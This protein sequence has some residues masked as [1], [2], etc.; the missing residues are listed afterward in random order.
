[1]IYIQT[2]WKQLLIIKEYKILPGIDNEWRMLGG[3]LETALQKNKFVYRQLLKLSR[4]S[5]IN[6]ARAILIK[7]NFF[8]EISTA[9]IQAPKDLLEEGTIPLKIKERVVSSI[10]RFYDIDKKK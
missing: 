5:T 9:I 10:N 4:Y 2:S 6:A 7:F 8:G 1:M 3:V